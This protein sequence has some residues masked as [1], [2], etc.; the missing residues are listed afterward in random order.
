[1][2]FSPAVTSGGYSLVVVSGLLTAVASLV[3]VHGLQGMQAAAAV[4][5]G[6]RSRSFHALELRSM[7]VVPQLRCFRASGIFPD[8]DLKLCLMNRQAD[9]FFFFLTI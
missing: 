9:L 7:V 8:Q 1:M 4:A 3:T 6:L 2:G 5:R